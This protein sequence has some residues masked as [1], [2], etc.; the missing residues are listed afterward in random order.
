MAQ[1]ARK[2]SE[3]L[4]SF[5]RIRGDRLIDRFY[6]LFLQSDERIRAMFAGTDFARQKQMLQH[7]ILM[8]LSYSR[9][10]A[11]GSLALKRLG[12]RHHGELGVGP[13][14]YKSFVDC[15]LQAVSELDPE[16][17][18]RLERSWRNDLESGLGEMR[19]YA[20]R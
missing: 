17:G 5:R 7:G 3:A 2:T 14:M 19:R 20:E 13:E 1:P 16:W 4:E 6:E 8:M 10:D 11:I 9:G 15:L 18:P 12:Q